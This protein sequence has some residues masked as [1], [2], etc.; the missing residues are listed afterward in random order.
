MRHAPVPNFS[1]GG[2]F[3]IFAARI[4]L[5]Y[6]WD[7][8]AYMPVLC[9]SSGS[10]STGLP[11]ARSQLP[12]V[13]NRHSDAR[14]RRIARRR[15]APRGRGCTA[16]RSGLR[17]AGAAAL[18]SLRSLR[19]TSGAGSSTAGTGA[20]GWV[21]RR[22]HRRVAGVHSAWRGRDHAPARQERAR[23]RHALLRPR[24][25]RPRPPAPPQRA[26]ARASRHGCA[27]C[28]SHAVMEM[29]AAAAA[30]ACRR[31]ARAGVRRAVR[32]IAALAAVER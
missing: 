11:N 3:A 4:A 27:S 2:I 14:C 16:D 5:P 13:A 32:S 7:P 30:A 15:D 21:Y 24:R 6:S 29:A 18:A 26:A 1:R 31:G 20:D 22:G 25:R 10:R 17:V 28:A 12:C 8:D 19:A 23:A 9:P